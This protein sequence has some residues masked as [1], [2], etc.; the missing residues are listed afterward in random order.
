MCYK[1][2][3]GLVK[4]EF[5]E[6]FVTDL[7]TVTRGHP[8]RLFVNLARHNVRKDFFLQTA[9]NYWI[10]LPADFDF[11]FIICS[12]II[13][14]KLILPTFLLFNSVLYVLSVF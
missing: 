8:Y 9:V 12:S 10:Y 5:S 6:F 3:V 11:S 13:L 14:I 1:I 4:L 2:V 7:V